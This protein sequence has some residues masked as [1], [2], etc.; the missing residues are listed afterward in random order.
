MGRRQGWQ[1]H[2]CASPK[3]GGMQPLGGVGKAQDFCKLRRE[4]AERQAWPWHACAVRRQTCHYCWHRAYLLH[5]ALP[6]MDT[7]PHSCLSEGHAASKTMRAGRREGCRRTPPPVQHSQPLQL[8]LPTSQTS[9]TSGASMWFLF[10]TAPSRR[11]HT[12]GAS[13]PT[14]RTATPRT[15]WREQDTCGLRGTGASFTCTRACGCA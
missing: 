12:V 1:P 3:R 7:R 10:W 14:P 11:C 6:A 2:A 9:S 5:K 4:D 8:P 15:A 13:P